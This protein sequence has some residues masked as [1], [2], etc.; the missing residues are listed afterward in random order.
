MFL[1]H[2]FPDI[3]CIWILLLPEH[4]FPSPANP[5]KHRHVT[6]SPSETHQACV[7]HPKAPH[8]SSSANSENPTGLFPDLRGEN[9]LQCFAFYRKFQY[10][11]SQVLGQVNL[12]IETLC[13]SVSYIYIK[14]S[15]N[16]M[17]LF[18]CSQQ[19][20]SLK[21]LC[22]VQRPPCELIYNFLKHLQIWTIQFLGL[23]GLKLQ[24]L[25]CFIWEF[26]T[27]VT[28]KRGQYILISQRYATNM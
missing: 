11:L 26:P 7:L 28:Y 19:I 12:Q 1:I 9:G 8:S 2:Y 24:K 13:W 5:F 4:S 10:F 17:F 22:G 27:V 6:F 18:T 20:F 25:Y 3:M 23:N 21:E 15:T 14:G 16:H